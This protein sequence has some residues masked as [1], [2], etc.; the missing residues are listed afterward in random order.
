MPYSAAS[1][2]DTVN[3]LR[4]LSLP[5]AVVLIGVGLAG[6][7]RQQTRGAAHL[8]PY[9]VG[10]LPELRGEFLRRFAS[11]ALEIAPS[12]AQSNLLMGISLVEE[13]RI[14][15]ARV[16]LERALAVNRRSPL[17][18]FY[19]AQVL[20][21]QGKDPLAVRQLEAELRQHFPKF[22]DQMKPQLGRSR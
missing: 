17:L 15:A 10:S 19:Y 7:E 20:Q 12:T 22:W 2:R 14:G 16:H 9:V 1:R 11:Q 5:L 4:S 18:L 13:G 8:R 21:A 6:F 3:L